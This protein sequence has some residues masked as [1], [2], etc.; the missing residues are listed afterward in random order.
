MLAARNTALKRVTKKS[1]LYFSLVI[2]TALLFMTIENPTGESLMFDILLPF[3]FM[4]HF[5]SLGSLLFDY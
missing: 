2:S 3:D 5:L 1:F 4:I